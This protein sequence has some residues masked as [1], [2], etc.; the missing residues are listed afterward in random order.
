LKLGKL[1]VSKNR[2]CINIGSALVSDEF[3]FYLNILKGVKH[4]LLIS[5]QYANSEHWGPSWF[6]PL[7][8]LKTMGEKEEVTLKHNFIR[9]T[10]M[11]PGM[12]NRLRS[13]RF[14]ESLMA[15][16]VP[17]LD[18]RILAKAM[19]KAANQKVT[20]SNSSSVGYYTGNAQI[21]DFVKNG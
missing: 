21:E 10:I 4:M 3:L 15:H 7:F 2:F 6:Q 18:V 1:S 9:T 13:D 17:T 19:I 16:L 20:S 5:A 14:G 8:Y 11:R 12:L